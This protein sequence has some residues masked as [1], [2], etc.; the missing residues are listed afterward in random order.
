MGCEVHVLNLGGGPLDELQRRAGL[1]YSL[2]LD[3]SQRQLVLM[4]LAHLA[5]ERPGFETALAAIAT[6][7]DNPGPE[8]F[9]HLLD[10]FSRARKP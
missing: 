2:P 10:L 5:A 1:R 3:E 8:M 9:S 6:P 4:A 7:I